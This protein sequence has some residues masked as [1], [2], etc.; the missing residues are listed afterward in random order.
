VNPRVKLRAK[1]GL[2]FSVWLVSGYDHVF[3][4]VS[5][6][7]VLYPSIYKRTFRTSSERITT[8][9]WTPSEPAVWWPITT[10]L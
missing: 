2:E 10:R 4:L 1:T 5:V 8:Q 9:R 7:I 6:V 3:I